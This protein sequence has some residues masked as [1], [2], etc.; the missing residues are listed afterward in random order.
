VSEHTTGAGRGAAGES[1]AH[2]A[3]WSLPRAA[4]TQLVAVYVMLAAV[5]Y[6]VPAA[7]P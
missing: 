1:D 2:A 7:T 4:G 6:L 5:C 3:L